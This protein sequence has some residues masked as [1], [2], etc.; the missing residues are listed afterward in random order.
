MRS[1]LHHVSKAATPSVYRCCVD[2]P[3]CLSKKAR[4]LSEGPNLM[5]GRHLH[6]ACSA[7]GGQPAQADPCRWHHSFARTAPQAMLQET[8]HY[9]L[10]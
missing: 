3:T 10:R 6:V 9:E 7:R 4:S 8:V 5:I 2:G 1:V